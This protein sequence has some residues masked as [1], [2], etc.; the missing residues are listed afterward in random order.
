MAAPT[1]ESR[2]RRRML[3]MT[4]DPALAAGVVAALPAGWEMVRPRSSDELGEFQDV[5]Q[6]RFVVVDLDDAGEADALDV[7]DAIRRDMMLNVPILCCGGDAGQRDAA[8]LARA[9]RF[10]ERGEMVERMKQF[11]EQY[12]WS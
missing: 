10:F 11:C 12:G 2:R 8:R 4:A 7:I 3:L 1:V 6:Y 9:D 5:L